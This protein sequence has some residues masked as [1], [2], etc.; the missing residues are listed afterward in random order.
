MK[1]E[2]RYELSV[3][4]A[5]GYL[6][7]L[8]FPV[9]EAAIGFIFQ[10]IPKYLSAGEVILNSLWIKGSP[11]LKEGGEFFNE[12]CMQAYAAVENIE[13]KYEQGKIEIPYIKKSQNGRPEVKTYKCEINTKIDR[14][15]LELCMGLVRP[16]GGNAQ[17]L[18]AGKRILTKNWIDGDKEILK[19][20]ELKIA[21]C[22]ACYRLVNMEAGTLKKV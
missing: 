3:G 10:P 2:I 21:A 15:L 18:T 16:N 17:V 9:V 20:D 12:A 14:D 11:K 22:T 4:G 13:Y 8:S 5:K 6:A 7:P 19:I 1:K